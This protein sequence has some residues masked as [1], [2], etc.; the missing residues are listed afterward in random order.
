MSQIFKNYSLKPH[1]TFNIDVRAKYFAECNSREDLKNIIGHKMFKREANFIIGAGSN[2]LFTEDY[3]GILVYPNIKGIKILQEDEYDITIKASCGENWDKF[4]K[5]CVNNNYGGIENLSWIPGKVGAVPIQNIGA[6]GVEARDRILEVE[7]LEMETGKI[8]I[9]SNEECHFG[10]R[11]SIFKNKYKGKYIILS[12]SF[13]LSKQPELVTD[14]GSIRQELEKYSQKNIKA[15]R[16]I[17]INIRKNKLPDPDKIG[18]AGSFFKN[19]VV[20]REKFLEIQDQ[21]PDM[22]YYQLSDNSIKIPAGWMIDKCGWKGKRIDDAGVY[23]KQ[24]LIL[25]NYGNA[26][27]QEIYKLS[28]EIENDVEQEFDISLEREVR[29]I[30]NG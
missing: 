15:I 25:V 3:N 1:N 10:Y 6:Y 29:V 26:K 17:V 24:A 11:E 22:P 19:P 27:G 28:Q 30:E 7:A 16:E 14:Y 21:Y 18:N 20:S 9:F 5:Y 2:I 12:V 4:V 13:K 8:K 23:S